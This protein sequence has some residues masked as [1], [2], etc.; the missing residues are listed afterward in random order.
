MKEL[1]T[2]VTI[3]ASAEEV[4]RILTDVARYA[5]WNPL[6]VSARGKVAP[7][8]KLDI[9]IRPPGKT[10]Q[11]YVVE[12]VRVVPGREFVWLGRMKMKGI[13]D[14]L[15]FFELHPDGEHRVRVVHREEFRGL[16]VPFVWRAFLD[17]RMREGFE[18]LNRRLKERAEQSVAE[19]G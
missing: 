19:P 3:A 2:E 16:L 17:T 18:A 11:P 6:I 4:F 7:G 15:H 14:G 13:L 1:V 5:E 10:D 9:R 8:K 12:V